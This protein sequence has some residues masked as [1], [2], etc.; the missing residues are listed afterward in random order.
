MG[1]AIKGHRLMELLYPNWDGST[2]DTI[3]RYVHNQVQEMVGWMVCTDLTFN[4]KGDEHPPLLAFKEFWETQHELQ[5]EGLRTYLIDV[6]P[7]AVRQEWAT[8]RRAP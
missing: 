3:D 6:L 1:A 7:D 5:P 2:V 4:F 8:L